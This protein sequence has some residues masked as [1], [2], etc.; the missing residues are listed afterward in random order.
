MALGY[1]EQLGAQVPC[2]SFTVGHHF[3]GTVAVLAGQDWHSQGQGL[4]YR[5]GYAIACRGPNVCRASAQQRQELVMGQVPQEEKAF[6]LV[7][8]PSVDICVG[9]S[10]FFRGKTK[11]DEPRARTAFQKLRHGLPQHWKFVL[12][13]KRDVTEKYGPMV[14]QELLDRFT[15]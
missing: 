2:V 11:P 7:H 5:R 6:A 14:L 4:K 10:K 15:Q 13:T 12:G 8:I 9:R 1:F 3:G